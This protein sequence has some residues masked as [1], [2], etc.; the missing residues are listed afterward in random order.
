MYD[1]IIFDA[2]DRAGKTTTKKAMEALTNFKYI[3]IDRMYFSAIAY[4]KLKKRGNDVVYYKEQFK[5]LCAN[6]NVLVI[7]LKIFDTNILKYRV[8][9]ENEKI[10]NDKDIDELTNIYNNLI[11]EY[12]KENICDIYILDVDQCSKPEH[13]EKQAK[14]LVK[15]LNL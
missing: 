2:I 11:E 1:I 14:R 7:Y 15:D 9:N 12:K 5:K 10:I 6:F 8:V 4:E 3:V 13:Y